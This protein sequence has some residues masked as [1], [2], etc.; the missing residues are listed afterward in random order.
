MSLDAESIHQGY[1]LGRLFAVL[2]KIQQEAVPG[3]NATIKDR[4]FGAASATPGRIFPLLLRGV[5]NNIAKLRRNPESIG[6]AI[7]LDRLISD[8]MN[9]IDSFQTI[10]CLE[11]QGTFAIGY[12]HQRKDLFTSKTNPTD[13]KEV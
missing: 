5:Q 3:A 12:Y 7:H 6:R 9:D 4:Y 13:T 2:E 8:I 11:D 10:L 1:R